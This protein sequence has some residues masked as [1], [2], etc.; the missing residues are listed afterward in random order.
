MSC[1]LD[2]LI[3]KNE[4]EKTE[5]NRKSRQRKSTKEIDKGKESKTKKGCWFCLMSYEERITNISKWSGRVHLISFTM[6]VLSC[7]L[8]AAA[9]SAPTSY[10]K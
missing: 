4:E 1:F 6:E 9:H 8:T 2:L 7:C 5:K 10:C 3:R